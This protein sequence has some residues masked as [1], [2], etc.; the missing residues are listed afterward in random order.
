MKGGIFWEM[1]RGFGVEMGNGGKR[2]WK[3]DRGKDGERKRD[4]VL[5]L[6]FGM[7]RRVMRSAF[8][9]NENSLVFFLIVAMLIVR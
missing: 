5:M 4:E 2:G 3:R 7:S 6:G 9:E 8:F 1:V